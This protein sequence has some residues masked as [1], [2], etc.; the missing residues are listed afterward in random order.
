MPQRV[1]PVVAAALAKIA[2]NRKARAVHAARELALL[3][4]ESVRVVAA[5][6]EA[7]NDLTATFRTM[8]HEPGSFAQRMKDEKKAMTKM[9]TWT[10]DEVAALVREVQS[11]LQHGGTKLNYVRVAAK[12]SEVTRRESDG[13]HRTSK[14]CQEAWTRTLNPNIAKGSFTAAM[15]GARSRNRKRESK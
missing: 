10:E 14:Q 8:E 1:H 11:Q 6:R 9:G 7:I 3:R 5:H 12:V 13:K 4:A 15:G 2:Q